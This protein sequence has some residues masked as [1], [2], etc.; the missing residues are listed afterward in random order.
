[1]IPVTDTL[2][3]G[4]DEISIT[5]IRAGGPGGQNVNKVS[6]AAQ[7]RFDV[8][9]SPTLNGRVKERLERI[10]GARLTKDSVIVITANRF[11]TQEA[12][13]RDAV[14]RLVEMI[15]AAAHRP[16]FRVPTRPSRAEK[17]RRLESKAKRGATKQLR[18]RTLRGD[19]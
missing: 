12:N 3:I 8:R 18:S 4:D 6:T 15:A 16:K 13:R 19:D 5:Y 2:A 10:A 17:R 7:L 11:R 1:M 9:N 14:D